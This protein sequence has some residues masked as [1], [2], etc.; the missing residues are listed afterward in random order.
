MTDARTPKPPPSVSVQLV[1]GRAEIAHTC[2]GG[3]R[4]TA[5]LN[6][7]DW[8]VVAEAPLTVQPSVCCDRCGLHGWIDEGEF[9]T[10]GGP[11]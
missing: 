10:T 7:T 1:D 11:R 3:E 5:T 6:N 4:I 9:W 8:T 2:V